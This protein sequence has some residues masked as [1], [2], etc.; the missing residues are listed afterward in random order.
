MQ[1]K[2]R[3]ILDD[4]GAGR[5]TEFALTHNLQASSVADPGFAIQCGSARGYAHKCGGNLPSIG[6]RFGHTFPITVRPEPMQVFDPRQIQ[7]PSGWPTGA[8]KACSSALP[9]RTTVHGRTPQGQTASHAAGAP[10][11]RSLHAPGAPFPYNLD[12]AACC[13]RFVMSLSCL[14][15]FLSKE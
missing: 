2:R 15:V 13:N 14:F 4:I 9:R 7:V 1:G 11:N 3:V 10:S 12:V 5:Q 6:R 8:S